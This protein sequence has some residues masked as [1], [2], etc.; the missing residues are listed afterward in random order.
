MEYLNKVELKGIVGMVNIQT[1]Q[2]GQIVNF[3]MVTESL[4]RGAVEVDW[5]NLRAIDPNIELNKGD[6]V[7]VVGRIHQIRH[8]DPNGDTRT[9][10]YIYADK[11]EKINE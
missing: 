1:Y 4:S 7:H 6:K 9:L 8:A 10:Y 11:V 2:H 3:S 5:W